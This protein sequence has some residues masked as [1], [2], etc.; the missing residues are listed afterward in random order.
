MKDN[1][2]KSM[3]KVLMAL[4]A[5]TLVANSGVAQTVVTDVLNEYGLGSYATVNGTLNQFTP[6]G[7]SLYSFATA[8]QFGPALP[9]TLTYFYPTANQITAGGLVLVDAQGPSDVIVFGN[10]VNNLGQNFDF[11]SFYSLDQLGA[12]A[13]NPYLGSTAG[14]QALT[15][16]SPYTPVAG[17][18]GFVAGDIITYNFVSAVPEPATYGAWAAALTLVPLGVGMVRNLRRRQAA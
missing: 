5:S 1:M 15:E 4:A 12:P 16:G 18:A 10:N 8:N 7:T 9:P 13:D 11:A 14:F 2:E 3:Q 6:Y 17:Q